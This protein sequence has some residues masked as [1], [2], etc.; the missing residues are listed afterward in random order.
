MSFYRSAF[1]AA[2]VLMLAQFAD[3]AGPEPVKLWPDGA[4]GAVGTEPADV[5]ELR[6]YLPEEGKAT[7]AG[8]CGLSGWGLRSAG[9]RP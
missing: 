1:M 8:D 7:G 4:P 2:V 3:A 5:P 6:V 9:H